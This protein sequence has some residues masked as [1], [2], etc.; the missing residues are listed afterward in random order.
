MQKNGSG[1]LERFSERKLMSSLSEMKTL[2]EVAFEPRV[3]SEK[4]PTLISRAARRLG[5]QASR[6]RAFFYEE[7]RRVDADE[8]RQARDR[9]QPII[10]KLWRQVEWMESQDADFYQPEIDRLKRLL[11]RFGPLDSA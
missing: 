3:G 9:A 6:A 11:S 7:A 2:V 8:W 5:V 1:D 4:Q 10:E